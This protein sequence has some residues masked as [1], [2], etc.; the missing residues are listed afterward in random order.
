MSESFIS[1]THECL[2]LCRKFL[3]TPIEGDDS[4]ITVSHY[5]FTKLF[6]FVAVLGCVIFSFNKGKICVVIL[7][8]FYM[9]NCI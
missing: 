4:V 2:G 8:Q 7:L 6:Y 3:D 5:I 9:E 1:G